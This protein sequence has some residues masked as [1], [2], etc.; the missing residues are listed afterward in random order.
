MAT[1]S[2]LTGEET[3]EQNRLQKVA[4]GHTGHRAK[5]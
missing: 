5:I 1:F 4:E 2:H 3:E